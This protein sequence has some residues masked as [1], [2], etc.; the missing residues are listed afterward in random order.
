MGLLKK[1]FSYFILD[2][3]A[4]NAPIKEEMK[5]ETELKLPKLSGC[6]EYEFM[7]H[8]PIQSNVLR[9]KYYSMFDD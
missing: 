9:T 5:E 4:I 6:I 2:E 7:D 1:L 8:S 3:N